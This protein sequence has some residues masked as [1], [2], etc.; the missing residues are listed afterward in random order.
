MHITM[1][2]RIVEFIHAL[3]MHGIVEFT[4]MVHGIL[5]YNVELT[6]TIHAHNYVLA[7]HVLHANG[8]L[9]IDAKVPE[10]SNNIR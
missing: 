7:Y 2:I 9:I 4:C 10:E 8:D 6:C 5:L 3:Y 1:I